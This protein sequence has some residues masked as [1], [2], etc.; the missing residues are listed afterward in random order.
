MS[1]L[2]QEHINAGK[3]VAVD[4][5]KYFYI[6]SGNKDEIV[7]LLH[8]FLT[9]SYHYRKLI[10]ILEGKYRVIA[11]DFLGIGL[12]ERPNTPLSHRMQAHYLYKFL[13]TVAEGKKVHVVVHDFAL[14]ILAFLLKEHPEHIKSLTITNGF[15]NLPKFRF[16]LPLSLLRIP[17]L[18][19][20]ISFLFRPPL[21]HLFYQLFLTKKGFRFDSEWEKDT[22]QL[23]FAGQNRKNTLEFIRNVDR[24]GHT[25]RDVEDGVKSLVGLRQIIIGESDFRISPYQTEFIKE[26]LRT[27]ALS[28]VPSCHLPMEECPQELASKIIYLVDSYSRNKTKTFQFKRNKPN[29]EVN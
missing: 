29:D 12:S 22:Y 17:V 20:L 14:P 8:G 25:L 5:V 10:R 18:G 1:P 2:L 3:Y 11:P 26:T 27:S 13:E 7:V 16:Y 6:D 24:S 21:L 9:T 28:V 19:A 15:L 23:L 4:G